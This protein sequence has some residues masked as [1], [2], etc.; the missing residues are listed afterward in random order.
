M[1]RQ[2][3]VMS[4]ADLNDLRRCMPPILLL[5]A[6]GVFAGTR[7]H[8]PAASTVNGVYSSPCCGEIT[9]VDGVMHTSGREI[10]F[11]VDDMKFGRV[12]DM[13]ES[14]QVENGHTIAIGRTDP[15]LVPYDV[16]ATSFQLGGVFHTPTALRFYEFK[17]AVHGKANVR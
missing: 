2:R 15:N 5:I 7:P 16:A 6:L 4:D 1:L 13:S 3:A 14:V 8:V 10:S 9:L 17:R 12:L 11:T